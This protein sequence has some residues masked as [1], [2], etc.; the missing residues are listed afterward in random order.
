RSVTGQEPW[1]PVGLGLGSLR[2]SAFA[3]SGG[4]LF[5]AFVTGTAAVLEDSD[6]NGATWKDPEVFPGVFVQDLA[7][8]RGTLYAARGD[9]LWQRTLPN[10][11]AP[12]GAGHRDLRFAL[13]GAQPFHDGATLRF[14]LPE[15]GVT[16]IEVLDVAG[17]RAA[18]PILGSWPAGPH[19]V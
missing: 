11:S 14:E 9:G 7:I 19:E 5:A 8:S 16:S 17:R 3:A 4:T 10:V 1:T 6:D 15:A 12:P 13:A 2:W 18:G